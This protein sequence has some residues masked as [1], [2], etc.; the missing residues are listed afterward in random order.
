LFCTAGD[1]IAT[2]I[3]GQD[4]AGSGPIIAV[5]AVSLVGTGIGTVL[6][7]GLYAI[8]QQRFNLL[9]DACIL[10]VTLAAAVLLIAPLGALGAALAMLAG[11]VAGTIVRCFSIHRL[12]RKMEIEVA[13]RGGAA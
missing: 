9:A 6:G 13:P 12:L 7:N 1:W 10:V 4:Y 8:Q 11:V 3:Y 5:L 2:A